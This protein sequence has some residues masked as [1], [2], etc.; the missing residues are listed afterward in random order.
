MPFV[1]RRI[2]LQVL[3]WIYLNV[4]PVLVTKA[5]FDWLVNDL[6]VAFWAFWRVGIRMCFV[7]SP[8]IPVFTAT[9][10]CVQVNHPIPCK[11]IAGFY[12]CS[13]FDGKAVDSFRAYIIFDVAML[14]LQTLKRGCRSMEMLWSIGC[15]RWGVPMWD[16][17]HA[18]VFCSAALLVLHSFCCSRI[19]SLEHPKL[20]RVIEQTSKRFQWTI[21]MNHM[22]I[23]PLQVWT[24]CWSILKGDY[25]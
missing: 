21:R 5:E 23:W 13:A 11:T 7:I 15:E 6:V 12:A 20:G 25:I 1:A 8:H 9:Y 17:S 22:R 24:V 18:P 10:W 19:L 2:K 3:L 14:Y 4:V 16:A